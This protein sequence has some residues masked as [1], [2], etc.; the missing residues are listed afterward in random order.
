MTKLLRIKSN[1]REG[2]IYLKCPNNNTI[3]Q[4]NLKN[5]ILSMYFIF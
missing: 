5:I 2:E 4:F 3:K 1:K